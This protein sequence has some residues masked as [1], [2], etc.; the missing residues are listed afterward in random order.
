MNHVRITNIFIQIRGVANLTKKYTN[1]MKKMV[2][3]RYFTSYKYFF[4]TNIVLQINASQVDFQITYKWFHIH[5]DDKPDFHIGTPQ[6]NKINN[7]IYITFHAQ[8]CD[9]SRIKRFST[10]S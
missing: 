2:S 6:V 7:K 9:K 5:H 3:V 8:R 4:Y 10:K 1:M